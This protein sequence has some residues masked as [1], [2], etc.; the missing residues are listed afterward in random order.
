MTLFALKSHNFNKLPYI[1]YAFL[2]ESIFRLDID[3]S[4]KEI[5]IIAN[6]NDLNSNAHKYL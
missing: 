4:L 6:D 2:I 3:K 1:L 5:V